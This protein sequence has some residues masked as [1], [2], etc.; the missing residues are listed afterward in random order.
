MTYGRVQL[1]N[2]AQALDGAAVSHLAELVRGEFFSN[3]EG[4]LVRP[5]CRRRV[6]DTTG[7]FS[8]RAES[9]PSARRGEGTLWLC[10][11]IPFGH[12]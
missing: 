6:F 1:A 9:A 10:L 5:S 8:R 11:E 4:P 12:A 7:T 3:A 2:H